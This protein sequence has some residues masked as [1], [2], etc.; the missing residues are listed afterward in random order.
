MRLLAVF[1][2]EE[3]ASVYL[4]PPFLPFPPLLSGR[5]FSFTSVDPGEVIFLRGIWASSRLNS[6]MSLLLYRLASPDSDTTDHLN[7]KISFLLPGQRSFLIVL[8]ILWFSWLV[9]SNY[10]FLVFYWLLSLTP[11]LMFSCILDPLSALFH[12]HPTGC[13]RI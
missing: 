1:W 4:P 6:N 2:V 5:H 8:F 3:V 9:F 7:L 11:A 13:L 10:S 12:P